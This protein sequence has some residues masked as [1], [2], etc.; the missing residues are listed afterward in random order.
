MRE[1]IAEVVDRV[2]TYGLALLDQGDRPEVNLATAQAELKRRLLP[3]ASARHLADY[4]AESDEGI[5]ATL[6]LAPGAGRVSAVPLSQTPSRGGP[7][8]LGIRFALVCWLD[9]IVGGLPVWQADWA[10]HRLEPVLYGSNDGAAKFWEQARLA[11]NRASIDGL[12]GYLLCVMLGFRGNL[13]GRPDQ[14]R[15]WAAMAQQRITKNQRQE[16]P[17]P[18]ELEPPSNVAPR[19]AA[20]GFHRMLIVAG[21]VLTLLVPLAAMATVKFLGLGTPP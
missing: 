18:N 10:S 5:K 19:T 2:L 20:A 21:L 3:D 8:F 11:E 9:E 6:A 13:R 12:E 7:A 16:W 15:G 1:E 17:Y 4:G 14:V